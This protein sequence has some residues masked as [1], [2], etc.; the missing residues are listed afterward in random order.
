MAEVS[1][2]LVAVFVA[3]WLIYVAFRVAPAV[4]RRWSVWGEVAAFLIFLVGTVLV[5]VFLRPV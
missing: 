3:A 5:E 2:I 4:Q 1:A